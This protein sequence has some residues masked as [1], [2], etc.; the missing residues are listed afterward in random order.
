MG[1]ACEFLDA[2]A[3]A[4]YLLGDAIYANPLLLGYAWQKGWIPLSYESLQRAIELNGVM[5][6]KNLSAFEWGRAAAHHGVQAI[7]PDLGRKADT[8]TTVIPLPETLATLMERTVKWLTQYQNDAK[9]EK[10][11]VGKEWYRT[12]R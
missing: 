12:V 2:N 5:V 1:S 6:E 11:S 3:L 4:V 10:R 8:A 9:P 7:A